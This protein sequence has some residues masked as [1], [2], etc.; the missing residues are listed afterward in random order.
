M[1]RRSIIF[2]FAA[3][4]LMG[5]LAMTA[6]AATTGTI[7]GTAKNDVLKGTAKADVL[8]GKAGNDKLFG[9]AGNDT[10]IGGPGADTLD[11]GSGN[12]T[13]VFD[14][15]D[16]LVKSCEILKGPKPAVS[17]ASVS[18]AEGNSGSTTFSFGVRLS[19]R[20]PFA[21]G[22]SYATTDGSA[23]AGSDY[24]SASGKVTFAPG[25]TSAAIN[26]AVTG[27][28]TVEQDETFTVS[29]SAPTN[30]TLGAASATGTIRNDDVVKVR[31]GAYSGTN[32]QGKPLTFNVSADGSSVSDI[33]TTIDLNC[34][35]VQGFTVTFP[36]TSTGSFPI[37][38]DLSFDANE[39]DV[40]SDGTTLDI[41]FH[42]QL[43]T[44]NGASGTLRVD[45][46]IP[47]IPG[48]CSTGDTSW[49]AS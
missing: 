17:I 31:A 19:H 15:Q 22:V 42:G 32:S 38:S 44:S 21:V 10:L 3:V 6:L 30:A 48:I 33:N 8:N 4:A 26:I 1:K 12:D 34:T 49:T 45:L 36:L 13:A 16:K 25:Q 41:K 11:C 24:Q 18:A 7:N 28:T 46:A 40:A 23:T 20:A 9:M 39:H 27:D 14:A 2:T 37:G 29:L 35:E 47:G 43:T 5:L